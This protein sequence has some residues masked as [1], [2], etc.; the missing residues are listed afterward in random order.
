MLAL[1]AS[2]GPLL[3]G[4]PAP[5]AA[6]RMQSRSERTLPEPEPAGRGTSTLQAR[7]PN[8]Q[9]V[10]LALHC[11]AEAGHQRQHQRSSA[12]DA[13]PDHAA[14]LVMSALRANDFTKLL[15]ASLPAPM[16][17]GPDDI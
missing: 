5:S 1:W 15:I 2:Q 14:E 11:R 4:C 8:T 9:P 10:D 12:H 17:L 6:V 3:R 13:G 16:H 7:L